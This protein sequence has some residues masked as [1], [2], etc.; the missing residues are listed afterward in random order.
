MDKS[1]QN[2]NNYVYN[3]FWVKIIGCLI[4]SEMIDSLGREESI[5]KRVSSIHFYTDLLGGFLIAL[6]LWEMVRF[7]IR[8]LDKKFDWLEHP[9]QRI[10]MQLFFGVLAPAILCFLFTLLFMRFA[11][12][13]DI[14]KT[15]WLYNE[16][17]VVI[18][19]IITINLIYFTWWLY[20]RWQSVHWQSTV[21]EASKEEKQLVSNGSEIYQPATIEVSKAGKNILLTQAEIAYVF[22]EGSFVFI[23][24]FNQESFATTYAL[25]ELTK[26]LDTISFFRANRQVIISRISC[27][28]YQNIENGKISIELSPNNK[29]PVIISQKKAKDFRKWVAGT[30]IN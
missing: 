11:Y 20:N 15:E 19:I 7:I 6:I 23:K 18:L 29:F 3:D 14:F 13:Q 12:S 5:F 25:D 1:P 10:S 30:S 27:K 2:I 9:V 28:A 21:A 16:F 26:K 22:L 24:T 8:R 17:Y 4:A